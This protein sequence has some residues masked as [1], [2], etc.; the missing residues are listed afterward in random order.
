MLEVCV[1]DVGRGMLANVQTVETTLSTHSEAIQW[2]LGEG[3]TTAKPSDEWAQHIPEDAP[4]NPY[5]SEVETHHTRNHHAGLGLWKLAQI[6][7]ATGG[8]LGIWSGD[9]RWQLQDGRED[10]VPAPFWR[11]MI[12]ALRL[13]VADAVDSGG[14]YSVA[15]L[16]DLARRLDL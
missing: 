4:Q 11:G 10:L 13:P 7:R 15:Q 14:Q 6:V 2:C 9:A 1:A 3:H 12:V 8:A 5:G 16:E